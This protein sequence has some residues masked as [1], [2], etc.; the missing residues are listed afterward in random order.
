[1]DSVAFNIEDQT[2]HKPKGTKKHKGI[3]RRQA[4]AGRPHG[5][6]CLED[7]A[8]E[9]VVHEKLFIF[10]DRRHINVFAVAR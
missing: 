2:F 3:N 10:L 6:K 7:P 5:S 8:L 1:M 9:E 4:A